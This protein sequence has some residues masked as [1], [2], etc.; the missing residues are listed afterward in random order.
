MLQN[1]LETEKMGSTRKSF[2]N[3]LNLKIWIGWS[4]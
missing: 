4:W 1:R 3:M 2:M